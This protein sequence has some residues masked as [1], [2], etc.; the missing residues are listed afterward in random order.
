MGRRGFCGVGHG[1]SGSNP[2]RIRA[3]F[4]RVARDDRRA[5]AGHPSVTRCGREGLCR[6][7]DGAS[8][9]TAG[10][11]QSSTLASPR[12]TAKIHAAAV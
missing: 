1:Q 12:T 8:A 2:G 5:G 3:K 10:D 4:A 11:S 7:P 9:C 6:Q